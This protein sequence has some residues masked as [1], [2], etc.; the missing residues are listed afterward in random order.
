M[1]FKSILTGILIGIVALPTVTL[2]GSFVFSLIAGKTPTE[3]VQI[4]GEQIDSLI[5][6]VEVIETKQAGQEQVVSELQDKLAKEE[7]CRRYR[8]LLDETPRM[9]QNLSGKITDPI[10]QM[11]AYVNY[12]QEAL[13]HSGWNPNDSL[14][15][16]TQE[17]LSIIA[18]NKELIKTLQQQCNQ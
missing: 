13:Q 2:G 14:Y 16:E 7:A 17:N 8:E 10:L 6:R 4:L 1:K 11:E 15:Q 3:A 12:A 18:E 9:T 5:G